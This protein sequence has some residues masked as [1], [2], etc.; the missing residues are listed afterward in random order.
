M[1]AAVVPKPSEGREERDSA[2]MITGPMTLV[3]LIIDE[4]NA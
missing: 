2:V 4:S 3:E 1:S